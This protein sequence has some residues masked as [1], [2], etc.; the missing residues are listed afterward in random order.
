VSTAKILKYNHRN[1]PEI[2]RVAEH[3]H[4]GMTLPAAIVRRAPGGEK[5]R[6]LAIGGIGALIP[7]ISTR[8]SNRGEAIGVISRSKT[9]VTSLCALLRAALPQQRVD[10]YTSDS[11][12]GIE[13][14]I[15]LLDRGVTIL[16]GES[17]KGL[18]FEAVYLRDLGRS[19]PS[20]STADNRRMYMLCTRARNMLT[21]VDWPQLLRSHQMAALPPAEHLARL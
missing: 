10:M 4:Q 21:L 5:P 1:T 9:E 8:L 14:H 20:T 11:A 17:V 19:L 15:H 18:E 3:F 13:H 6:I 2:A 7:L 16:T 12:G